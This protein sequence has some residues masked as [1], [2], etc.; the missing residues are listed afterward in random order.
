M[1]VN[2]NERGYQSPTPGWVIVRGAIECGGTVG[3]VSRATPDVIEQSTA[4][5]SARRR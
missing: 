2:T 5:P 4:R 1:S 3:S